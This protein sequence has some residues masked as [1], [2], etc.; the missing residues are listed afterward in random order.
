M[1]YERIQTTDYTDLHG[2]FSYCINLCNLW[3]KKSSAKRVLV[4]LKECCLSVKL[5]QLSQR[6]FAL[7]N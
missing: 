1:N 4:S 5:H 7:A 6:K 2:F 3:P